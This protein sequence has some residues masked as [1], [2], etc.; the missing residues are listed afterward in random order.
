MDNQKY[1]EMK[2]GKL[3]CIFPVKFT[4]NVFLINVFMNEWN[5]SKMPM[6]CGWYGLVIMM[7]Y[8]QFVCYLLL[9]LLLLLLLIH[10]YI[11]LIEFYTLLGMLTFYSALQLI[12]YGNACLK[13]CVLSTD[14]KIF[15]SFA[16]LMLSGMSFQYLAAA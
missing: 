3:H 5:F 16:V 8:P 14:L 7:F 11:V 2:E 1:P 6:D 12:Y 15:M 13:K 4:M 9:L 10:S